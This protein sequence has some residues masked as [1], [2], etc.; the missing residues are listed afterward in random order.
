MTDFAGFPRGT[1]LFLQD[2]AA[3]N[4]KPWFDDHRTDYE[5]SWL[6]PARSFV[7]AMGERLADVVPE[8]VAE[9]KVNG[10]IRRINRDTRFSKDKTPYKDHLDIGFWEGDR[11]NVLSGFWLRIDPETLG[12][13]V[14]VHGFDKTRLDRFRDAVVDRKKSESLGHAVAAVEASGNAL[15]GEHYK[16]VPAGYEPANEFQERFV[17]FASLHTGSQV[18]H[19]KQ[20]H[21]AQFVDWLMARWEAQLPLHRWLVDELG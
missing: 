9:P 8:I 16:R 13:G 3:N 10:S 11:K 19:P 12:L 1:V 17:R 6:D 15:H 4:T 14:G 5:A 21:S 2:I 18:A 7:V 20:L